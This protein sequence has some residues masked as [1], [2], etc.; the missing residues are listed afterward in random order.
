MQVL[1]QSTASTASLRLSATPT[2]QKTSQ[3]SDKN[4]DGA[5][6]EEDDDDDD[7]DNGNNDVVKDENDT[8]LSADGE[9]VQV[10]TLCHVVHNFFT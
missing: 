8:D 7:D 3:G 9:E 6:E 10:Y 5:E 2:P 1:S 4:K